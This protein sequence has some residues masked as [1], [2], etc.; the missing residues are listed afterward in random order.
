MESEN[1]DKG[2]DDYTWKDGNLI[3][4]VL[5]LNHIVGILQGLCSETKSA[6]FIS[7]TAFFFP[8]GFDTSTL[9][10]ATVLEKV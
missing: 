1:K 3:M 2:R 5:G 7:T 4:V 9:I 10:S 6:N 8:F